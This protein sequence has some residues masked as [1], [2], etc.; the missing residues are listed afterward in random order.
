[1]IGW[2]V[3]S[4][5]RMSAWQ[6]SRMLI[7]QFSNSAHSFLTFC[8]LICHHY[9]PL[10]IGGE[11]RWGKHISPIKNNAINF[12]MVP[13]LLI[14]LYL[15]ISIPCIASKRLWCHLLHIIHTTSHT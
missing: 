9:T 2:P 4:S 8:T 15:Y 10:S 6:S 3:R 13:S 14:L 12:F 11:F 7:W 1:V 5:S